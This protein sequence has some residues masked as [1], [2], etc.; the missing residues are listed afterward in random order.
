MK[1]LGP[2]FLQTTPHIR[3]Y[4][5]LQK[6]KRKANKGRETEN[7][8]REHVSLS[9][10][11]FTRVWSKRMMSDPITQSN[12]MKRDSMRFLGKVGTRLK[13]VKALGRHDNPALRTRKFAVFA[14]VSGNGIAERLPHTM[15]HKKRLSFL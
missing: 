14:S 7:R 5:T 13:R 3:A 9:I 6:K 8:F 11:I 15:E 10:P 4:S 2:K 12:A 1:E